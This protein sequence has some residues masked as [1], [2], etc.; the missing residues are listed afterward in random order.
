MANQGS[1]T[2]S[3]VHLIKNINNY[4]KKIK[5]NADMLDNLRKQKSKHKGRLALKNKKKAEKS[6][7]KRNERIGRID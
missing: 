1:N 3:L 2:I 6:K 4:E 5:D 7:Q